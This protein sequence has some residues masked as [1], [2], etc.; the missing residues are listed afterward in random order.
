[1]GLE[2]PI[3]DHCVHDLRTSVERQLPDERQDSK[4]CFCL[5]GR[6]FV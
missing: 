2:K 3:R 6:M 4:K 1:M 5:H